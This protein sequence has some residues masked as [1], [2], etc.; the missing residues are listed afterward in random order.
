MLISKRSGNSG[1]PAPPITFYVRCE[2]DARAPVKHI[3]ASTP[4]YEFLEFE[5]KLTNPF[6]V[7]ILTTLH[8]NRS[9]SIAQCSLSSA[10]GFCSDY[11]L[12][13]VQ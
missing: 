4:L 11:M 6:Q 12:N 8:L 9:V 10:S 13:Q 7:T 5:V 3:N 2:A 1:P